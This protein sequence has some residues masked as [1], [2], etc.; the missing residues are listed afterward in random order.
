MNFTETKLRG[1]FIVEPEPFE[2]ERG[3]FART[4]CTREFAAHDLQTEFVQCNISF[5]KNKG[6]LRGMHYQVAPHQEAKLVRCTSG[7]IYD[8]I[9]DMRPDSETYTQWIAV[10][11]SGENRKMLYIPK[12]FAHGFLTLA[13]NTEIFYQ[14]SQFYVPE[15]GRGIRWNDPAFTID[16]PESVAEISFKDQNYPDFHPET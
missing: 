16:W 3:L 6:T 15:A 1:A 9:I 11:L 12:D 13:D 7:V 5:N 2:D 8:V 14:M 4:F 10:E